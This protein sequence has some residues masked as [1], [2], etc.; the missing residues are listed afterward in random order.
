MKGD[1]ARAGAKLIEWVTAPERTLRDY[2]ENWVREADRIPPEG[3]WTCLLY[4]SR[5]V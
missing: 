1:A 4:T 2:P 5:C 3:P